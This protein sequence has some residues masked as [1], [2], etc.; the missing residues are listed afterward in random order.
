MLVSSVEELRRFTPSFDLPPR[1]ALRRSIDLLAHA[2][3]A[4]ACE[5]GGALLSLLCGTPTLV[6]GHPRSRLRVTQTENFL[7]TPVR[8]IERPDYNF[9][10]KEVADAAED[11]MRTVQLAGSRVHAR[12]RG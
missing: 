2:R 1:E 7:S 11:F 10:V 5:S 6:F 4:L 8:Y 9:T 12:P 3:F